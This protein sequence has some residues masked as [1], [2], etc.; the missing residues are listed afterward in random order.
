MPIKRNKTKEVF[1]HHLSKYNKT[2]NEPDLTN[3]AVV[4]DL[5]DDI[6]EQMMNRQRGK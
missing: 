1:K 3:D 5:I 6:V 4:D 2:H